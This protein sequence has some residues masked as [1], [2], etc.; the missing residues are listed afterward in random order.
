MPPPSPQR[1]CGDS[2]LNDLGLLDQEGYCFRTIGRE[3]GGV[4][5]LAATATLN[6]LL[7]ILV[8]IL[9]VCCP[10]GRGEEDG[11]AARSE[12]RGSTQEVDGAPGR[13][14]GRYDPQRPTGRYGDKGSALRAGLLD[15]PAGV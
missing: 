5:Y 6:W 14:S 9:A 12:R 8:F 1:A 2:A 15:E 10:P 4:R 13:Y 3:L 7:N 11:E